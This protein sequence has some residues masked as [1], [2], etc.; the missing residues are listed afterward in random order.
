MQEITFTSFFSSL[1]REHPVL[2][3]V[4]TTAEA[5]THA[6]AKS[7]LVEVIPFVGAAVKLL[8]AKDSI[9]DRLYAAKLAS[10]IRGVG[11]FD[12]AARDQAAAHLLRHGNAKL[13]DTLLLVLD[14]MTDLDK[15]ELLGLLFKAFAKGELTAPQLR[16]LAVAVDVGFADD[17]RELL[18][19]HAVLS[20]QQVQDCRRRLVPTG[21]TAIHVDSVPGGAVLTS[22]HFT[23][24]G[25]LFYKLVNGKAPDDDVDNLQAA[26][27]RPPGGG[28]R[29]KL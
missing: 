27:A 2:E 18:D 7:Q 6:V 14:R 1:D 9:A 28:R 16:R 5:V 12:Q 22:Y 25:V 8:Q 29:Q 4:L 10:F 26:V 11:T 21:L 19:P 15:P 13:G 17:L 23:E 3:A 20:A 24:L